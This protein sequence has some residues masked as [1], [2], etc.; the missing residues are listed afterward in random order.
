M[1]AE[2]IDYELLKQYV[3]AKLHVVDQNTRSPIAIKK[4]IAEYLSENKLITLI[5]IDNSL[6][7]VDC[8]L[9]KRDEILSKTF[10]MYCDLYCDL[11]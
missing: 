5:N 1:I 9:G 6:V 3:D 10:I 11:I 2:E 8:T 7:V 4:A